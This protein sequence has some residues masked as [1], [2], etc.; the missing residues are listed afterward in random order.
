VRARAVVVD[1]NV[2]FS[3]ELTDLFLTFATRRL[4]DIRW[5][6]EILSEVRRSLEMS[7]RL[8]TAAIDRRL[9][10]MQRALPDATAEVPRT[11]IEQMRVKAN[12]RHVLAL[13]VAVGS[14]A[15]VTFNV[16]D[17]PA[18]HCSS[19]GVEVLT[20]DDL[21]VETLRGD[22]VGVMKAL[23][24]IVGR[25]KLPSVTADDLLDR[26]QVPLPRFVELARDS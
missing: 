13:A 3:I 11:L 16:R 6:E 12:D 5:S 17:F 14:D 25:R 15:I 20:P 8:P 23:H 10:A 2:L 7:G 19:L 4:I 22:S 1:A 18:D 9:A 21:A 24:E 26:W